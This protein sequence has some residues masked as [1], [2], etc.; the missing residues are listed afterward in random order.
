MVCDG[1]AFGDLHVELRTTASG[2]RVPNGF[3]KAAT[4]SADF[5]RAG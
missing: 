4:R 3:H 5:Y 1:A 2:P